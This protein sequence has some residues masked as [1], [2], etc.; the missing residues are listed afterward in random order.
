M[1]KAASTVT[2]R[3]LEI[4]VVQGWTEELKRLAPAN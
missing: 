1:L 4:H 2:S 3:R